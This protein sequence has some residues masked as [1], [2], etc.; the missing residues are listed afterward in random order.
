VNEATGWEQRADHLAAESLAAGDPTGWFERLYEEGDAGRVAMPWNREHP[1]PVLADWVEQ[2]ALQ[3]RG[4][5]ALVVGCGLGGDAELIAAS[6]FA[7]TAFDVSETAIRVAR[8]RFAESTV[9]YTQA[10]LLDPPPEWSGG[11]DLVVEVF[12]V[13]ALPRSVRSTAVSNV[14]RMVG[15]PGTLIVVAAVGDDDQGDGPPW[16]LTRDEIESFAHHGLTPEQIEV[17]EHP[18]HSGVRR[19]RA[20]FRR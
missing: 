7:T 18:P 16:P 20:E 1:H 4:R 3:G 2:R 6:G 19:W 9:Q 17:V 5:P 11:F 10:D 14:S 15:A 12:T 13:Q 8:A